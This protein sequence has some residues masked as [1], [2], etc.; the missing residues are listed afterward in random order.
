MSVEL[1]KELRVELHYGL[2]YIGKAMEDGPN[3]DH[4]SAKIVEARWAMASY[5][6][7]LK[8]EPFFRE[9][10]THNTVIEHDPDMVEE[11]SLAKDV[12]GGVKDIKICI[13]GFNMAIDKVLKIRLGKLQTMDPR[14]S[15]KALRSLD[16]ANDALEGCIGFLFH[17]LQ[18]IIKKNPG[19]Y[20]TFEAPIPAPQEKSTP[21]EALST[22]ALMENR[23][24]ADGPGREESGEP[25]NTGSDEPAEPATP[26]KDGTAAPEEGDQPG[27]NA[28]EPSGDEAKDPA[29][30]D[31][32]EGFSEDQDNQSATSEHQ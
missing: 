3:K 12:A 26:A 10:R 13:G 5:I 6:S 18:D 19:V 22:D 25:A 2:D 8:N 9:S 32:T 21:A 16:R 4:A 7:A 14:N 1:A 31:P 29:P 20:P 17:E 24:A 30:S 11:G 15:Y 28:P 27:S 23:A